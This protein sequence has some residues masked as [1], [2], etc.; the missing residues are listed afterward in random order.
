MFEFSDRCVRRDHDHEGITE[1]FCLFE[2]VYMSHVEE[3]KGSGRHYSDHFFHA[4][5]ISF[6]SKKD[7]PIF[8]SV[9]FA[10]SFEH[11]LSVVT[12]DFTSTSD[13]G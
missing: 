10:S 6:P 2:I 8:F 13:W 11:C 7:E 12:H 5:T 4:L 3:I 9:C 1:F